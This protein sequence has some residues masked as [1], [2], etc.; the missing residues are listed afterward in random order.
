M[1]TGKPDPAKKIINYQSENY[2]KPLAPITNHA[3]DFLAAVFMNPDYDYANLYEELSH[4]TKESIYSITINDRRISPDVGKLID[5]LVKDGKVNARHREY[6]ARRDCVDP[7]E[8]QTL[9][10][11]LKFLGDS[12]KADDISHDDF[13]KYEPKNRDDIIT[14]FCED[15]I[16]DKSEALEDQISILTFHND[17]GALFGFEVL[18]PEE[19]QAKR[20]HIKSEIRDI[21]SGKRDNLL[22][23]LTHRS[24]LEQQF[25]NTIAYI[26][27]VNSAAA[28]VTRELRLPRVTDDMSEAISM[29]I[30]ETIDDKARE[31]LENFVPELEIHDA[32]LGAIVA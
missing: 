5:T 13:K 11:Y 29:K 26:E 14:K 28:T 16:G 1:N 30:L 9:Q 27:Q 17:M 6:I 10:D 12:E 7:E 8:P 15:L 22:Q 2:V 25:L 23:A 31:I 4:H 3:E 32:E 24:D 19:Y 18:T 21:L 20:Q